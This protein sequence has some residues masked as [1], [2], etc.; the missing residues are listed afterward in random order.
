MLSYPRCAN[1]DRH[2][3]NFYV[4]IGQKIAKNSIIG[5]FYFICK[6]CYISFSFQLTEGI[7]WVLLCLTC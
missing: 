3:N 2:Q 6:S 5:E 4:K 1:N 7:N